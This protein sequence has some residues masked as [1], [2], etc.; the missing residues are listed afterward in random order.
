MGGQKNKTKLGDEAEKTSHR[1]GHE[2]PFMSCLGI[3]D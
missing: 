2:R 3:V 1:C